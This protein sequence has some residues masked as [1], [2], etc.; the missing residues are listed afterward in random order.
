MIEN[1][2]ELLS[3]WKVWLIILL[4]C[5]I[6]AHFLFEV[7]YF[8]RILICVVLAKFFKRKIH[9]LEKSCVKGENKFTL[10]FN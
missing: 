8:I 6:G 1:W 3:D 4:L 10:T 2:D 5:Y 7:L 9:I